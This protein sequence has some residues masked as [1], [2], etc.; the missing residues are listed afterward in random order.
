MKQDSRN[1]RESRGKRADNEAEDGVEKPKLKRL[2]IVEVN[3]FIK[4][5][6]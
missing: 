2:S 1:S 5:T 4:I 6:I 3:Q